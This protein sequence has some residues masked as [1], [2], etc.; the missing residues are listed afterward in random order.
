MTRRILIERAESADQVRDL[1]FNDLLRGA[2]DAGLPMDLDAW[3]RWR[4]LRNSTSHAYDEARAQAVALRTPDF[5]IDADRLL[6]Q[7]MIINRVDG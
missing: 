7:L 4:E 6:E 1:S 5:A 3:R 2:L